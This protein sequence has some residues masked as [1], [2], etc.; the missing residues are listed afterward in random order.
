[1]LSLSLNPKPPYVIHA[2]GPVSLH[3]GLALRAWSQELEGLGLEGIRFRVEGLTDTVG[4]Q[5]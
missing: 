4:F 5:V 2:L 3:Y 1:M